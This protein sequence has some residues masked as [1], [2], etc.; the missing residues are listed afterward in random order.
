MKKGT[1]RTAKC[2]N[3]LEINDSGSRHIMRNIYVGV[4]LV[5]G[6]KGQE[7]CPLLKD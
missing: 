7:G 3:G 5:T 4:A 2:E 1:E 6:S